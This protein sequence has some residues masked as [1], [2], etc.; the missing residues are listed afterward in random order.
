MDES[1]YDYLKENY[2][3]E[4]I[5]YKFKR[6]YI[7]NPLKAIKRG[8]IVNVEKPIKED[9]EYLYI[10]LNLTRENTS[11][12]FNVS[13]SLIKLWAKYYNLKKETNKILNNT[14]N[15]VIKKFGVEYAG[16]S[17]ICQE[18][19]KTTNL[20][21]YGCENPFQN[22]EIKEEMRMKLAKTKATGEN[23]IYQ[24]DQIEN[25]PQPDN[26]SK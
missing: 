2:N 24:I 10:T 20:K 3:I 7:K 23:L 4:N 17:K 14:K 5:D 12:F 16:Q 25:A 13:P 19:A 6:D 26:L 9:F 21:K 22:D 18:K 8:F 1:I 15:T 11:K